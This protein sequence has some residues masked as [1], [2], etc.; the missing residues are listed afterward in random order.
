MCS[1]IFLTLACDCLT[2]NPLN[3]ARNAV[4]T[5]TEPVCQLRHINVDLI[6]HGEK[7][8]KECSIRQ[9]RITIEKWGT[10]VR[11]LIIFLYLS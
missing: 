7:I 3:L 10:D 1:V 5:L 8:S 4:N 2:L 6:Q 9:F 11:W